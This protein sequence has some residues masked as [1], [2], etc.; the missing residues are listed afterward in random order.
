MKDKDQVSIWCIVSIT[1]IPLIM[2]L[3]NSMLI[4]VLPKLEDKVGITSFQSSMII[5][6]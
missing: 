5:T 2:T 1:S 3:G 4:P 6:S